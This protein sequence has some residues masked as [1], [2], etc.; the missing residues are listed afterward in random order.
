MRWFM[1]L[2]AAV[3]LGGCAGDSPK[4]GYLP[5]D[6][7][8]YYP[9]LKA[10]DLQGHRFKLAVTDS[11]GSPTISCSNIKLPRDSE[12][13]GSKGISFFNTYLRKMIEA[14]NGVVDDAAQDVLNVKLKGL[15][16]DLV[17]FIYLRVWGLVEFDVVRGSD[18]RTYCSAMADGDE[19]APLGKTAVDTRAGAFR[20]MVSGSTRRAIESFVSDLARK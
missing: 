7:Y 6:D 15:S 2:A 10:V 3:A 20:K 8:A 18:S 1:C 5:A 13:E 11:R 19:G 14:N 12:L 4:Y 17:G 9:P 16:G